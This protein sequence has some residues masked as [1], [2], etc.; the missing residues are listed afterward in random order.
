MLR[1][2][3]L[4]PLGR[5]S[6]QKSNPKAW[7]TPAAQHQSLF[8]QSLATPV[9]ESVPSPSCPFPLLP[10]LYQSRW[11]RAP[12]PPGI[13]KALFP[14]FPE[15][16]DSPW[17]GDASARA[18]SEQTKLSQEVWVFRFTTSPSHQIRIILQQ[19]LIN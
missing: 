9:K 5:E 14:L 8:H 13:I 18:H 11:M 4:A 10:S 3:L 19:E 12:A 7:I 6:V 15:G 16:F 17:M 1:R 2:G